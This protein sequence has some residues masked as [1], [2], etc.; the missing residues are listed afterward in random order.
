MK[1][2]FKDTL[3]RRSESVATG[4]MRVIWISLPLLCGPSLAD[5]FN[6]FK[7]LL[8]TTVSISLWTFWVLILLS[9]LIATPISLAIIRIGA[10]AAAALSLWSALET[11]GSVSGIIGLAASVIAACV[12]LSAPLGDRFSDGASYGDERRFLLRAPGP[13]LLLLGP[14]AWLTS[15]AGLTVG[16]ILLLNKNFL[17]GSLIS[18]CG[19]PLAALASN[20]IYQLGKRW[21]VL[22]P[23]GILLHDHLSVGD[24]TLIP[25]NQLANFSPA[26]VETNALDLSQNSF[27]LSLEIQCLTPLSMMLRTGTRKTTNETSIV[28][29]FLINPVRPNV[30]LAEAQKRGLRV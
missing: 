4:I 30:L 20:A 15:V 24:P 3:G 8:R 9:T 13:V 28:E 21:L 10:P 2:L 12:A 17:F 6:D 19:F 14:L 23:A 1:L 7:L 11:S 22:V 29:S 25:R 27:G 16:P 5:S 26:K 18:L